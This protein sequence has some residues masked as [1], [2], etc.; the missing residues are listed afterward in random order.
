MGHAAGLYYEEHGVA[1]GHPL[2]LSAGL[3]GLGGYWAPNLPALARH[4][5]VIAYD[6]RGT[7]QSDRALPDRVTVDDLAADLVALMDGLKIERA[8]VMGHALGGLAGM[9]AAFMDRV[10][11]LVVVNGWVRLDPHTAR[12]FDARLRILRGAGVSAYLEAQPIFLYP[13]A[14][15]AQNRAR[16]DREI[17]AQIAH[18][19]GEAA[20][21]KRIAAARAFDMDELIESFPVPMLAI[22]AEDDILVPWT[23]T[24]DMMLTGTITRALMPRGGHACNITEPDHFNRNVLEFLGS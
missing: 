21:E 7:G 5:R 18:F 14:W 19:Q 23:V 15:I 2:I 4:Y 10:G 16:V 8:H 11:K 13:A 6:H 9:A 12:C 20:L 17:E 1:D 24:E 22:A 3:G